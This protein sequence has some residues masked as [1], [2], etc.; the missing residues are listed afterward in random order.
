MERPAEEFVE[1]LLRTAQALRGELAAHL[2]EFGLSE[3]RIAVLKILRGAEPHGCSQ[4]ELAAGL[5]QSESSVSALVKRMRGDRLLYR[6][7]INSDHRKWG[8]L[9]T[10]RGRDL[11]SNAEARL[12]PRLSGL[13]RRFDPQ[14]LRNVST[15]LRRLAAELSGPQSV[16]S[17]GLTEAAGDSV[18][19]RPASAA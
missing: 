15:L 14:E 19:A 11:L 13:F 7:R 4:A 17:A 12:R 3:V 18:P 6:L 2:G 5:G 10:E 1:Q 16:A 8:L 9:P